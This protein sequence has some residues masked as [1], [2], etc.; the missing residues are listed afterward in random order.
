MA[1]K[2]SNEKSYHVGRPATVGQLKRLLSG[3]VSDEIQ[4]IGPDGNPGVDFSLRPSPESTP[5]IALEVTC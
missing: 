1:P 2:E 4:L 3:M 5:G